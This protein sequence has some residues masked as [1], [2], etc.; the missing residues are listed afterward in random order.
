[1]TETERLIHLNVELEG[2][3]RVLSDRDSIHARTLLAQKYREYTSALDAFLA[4]EPAPQNSSAAAQ[5]TAEAE[6]LAN[7]ATYTAVKTAEAEEA[8]IIPQDTAAEEAVAAET[9]P[10]APAAH[11]TRILKAF[12]LNDKFRFR[13]ELFNGDD[14]SF[15]DTLSIIAD[16]PCYEDACDFI[17]NDMM[18]DAKNTD[19]ADF[20]AILAE[21]MPHRS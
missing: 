2:L 15:N 6:A 9:A 13:R 14:S 7:D 1:M 4:S 18:L 12:T 17:Y 19:V 5:I 16:M 20:M 11:N 3:L 8:E 10:Y 21:N